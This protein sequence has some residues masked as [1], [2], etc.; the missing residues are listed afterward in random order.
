MC[1]ECS[2]HTSNE[3]DFCPHHKELHNK[4]ELPMH[5]Q[6]SQRRSKMKIYF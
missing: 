6:Q 4:V 5:L 1:D 2:H 3:V